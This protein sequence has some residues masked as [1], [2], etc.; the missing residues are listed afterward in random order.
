MS[1]LERIKN[2]VAPIA[3]K[4]GVEKVWLFGSRARGDAK[5]DSDY[6]FLISCGRIHSLWDFADLW[7]DLE[8]AFLSKVDIVTDTADDQEFIEQI[9]KDEVVIYG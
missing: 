6:D 9:R 8:E 4:H 5:P 7:D 3:Q 1:E 2:I